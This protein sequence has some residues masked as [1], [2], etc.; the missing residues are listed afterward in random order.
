MFALV[1]FLHDHDNKRLHVVPA[2]D[3]EDFDPNH[4]ED[5][6]RTRSYSVYYDDV[7][8]HGEDTGFYDA[9]VL[10]L[11]GKLFIIN[12]ELSGTW[13]CSFLNTKVLGKFFVICSLEGGN[14]LANCN[15][16][17]VH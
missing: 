9:N 1:R 12:L 11:A 8:G 3:I 4:V 2:I 5:F 16:L 14:S 7:K 15:A 17:I 10:L 13:E 6:D